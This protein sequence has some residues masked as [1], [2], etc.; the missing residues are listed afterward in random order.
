LSHAA[1]EV[2]ANQ[3]PYI[4]PPPLL[5]LAHPNFTSRCIYT[6]AAIP[7]RRERVVGNA[8]MT[9]VHLATVT[10]MQV[11]QQGPTT[12]PVRPI[13]SS[14]PKA[15]FMHAGPA[16]VWHQC[17]TT[18][19]PAAS[20]GLSGPTT[21]NQ[22][23]HRF[24]PDQPPQPP[25]HSVGPT[26]T[27]QPLTDTISPQPQPNGVHSASSQNNKPAY[28]PT[29]NAITWLHCTGPHP[30]RYSGPT[31]PGTTAQASHTVTCHTG[32]QCLGGRGIRSNKPPTAAV[33]ASFK[34]CSHH[35]DGCSHSHGPPASCHSTEL[36]CSGM[37]GSFNSYKLQMLARAIRQQPQMSSRRWCGWC[38]CGG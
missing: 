19:T 16:A 20:S 36:G 1:L 23:N 7:V 22:P 24:G 18:N 31:H 38:R 15:G 6:G 25:A 13:S 27:S 28:Q 29:T 12:Y 9:K 30:P 3:A 5:Y 17:P 35:T 4:L 10:C 34:A 14:N 21:P 8:C 2:A 11:L 32:Y 37:A 26:T 33:E